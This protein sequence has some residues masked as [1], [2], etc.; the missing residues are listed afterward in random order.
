MYDKNLWEKCVEFHGHECPGLAIGFKVSEA[1]KKKLN[2]DFSKDEEIIC[3]T[4]NDA[5]GVD[6]VQVILGCS[7]GKG[8][9]LYRDRGKQAFSVF[10]R[11]T[12]ENIRIIL[13]KFKNEMDRSERQ[14]YLL[15]ADIE[16][17]F[18]FKNPKFSLPEKAKIFNSIT[19]EKCGETAAENK[20]R[21]SEGKKVCLD[22]LEDYS[23]GW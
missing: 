23:R 15:N 14:N 1:A 12:G 9:L 6:A 18:E 13:K 17:I 21:I 16:E 4:E 19:C 10:N 20:I 11:S 3:V 7:I 22:C 5:C 2:I 8:N